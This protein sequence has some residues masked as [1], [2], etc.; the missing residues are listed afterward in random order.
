MF[1]N[2]ISRSCAIPVKNKGGS[3]S[4]VL[5]IA[6]LLLALTPV[7]T[8]AAIESSCRATLVLHPRS[9]DHAIS[10]VIERYKM[11]AVRQGPITLISDG[12]PSGGGPSTVRLIVNGKQSSENGSPIL[13]GSIRSAKL[14]DEPHDSSL[15]I[16]KSQGF[17][18]VIVISKPVESKNCAP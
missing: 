2:G 15:R 4:R 18:Q 1:G 7:R 14:V 10:P 5:Q 16:V 8:M 9:A 3:N 6:A 12:S 17:R 11:A 13:G